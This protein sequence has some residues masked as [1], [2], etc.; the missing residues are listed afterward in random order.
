MNQR[1]NS[2]KVRQP[3]AHS[4]D[5]TIVEFDRPPISEV[6]FGIGFN[7]QE[8]FG[9]AHFGLFWNDIRNQFP[10]AEIREPIV[11]PGPQ[12]SIIEFILGCPPPSLILKPNS[13]IN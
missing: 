6:I 4:T 5:K 13:P 1:Q 3:K 8:N 7:M 10:L 9:E 11:P 12:K 2:S